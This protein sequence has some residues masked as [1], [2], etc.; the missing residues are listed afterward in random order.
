MPRC[1]RIFFTAWWASTY[2]YRSA[3]SISAGLLEVANV[4]AWR[5][6]SLQAPRDLMNPAQISMD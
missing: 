1:A 6:I 4:E 5:E 3:A 2:S